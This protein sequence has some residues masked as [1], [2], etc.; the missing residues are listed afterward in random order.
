MS[1]IR[2]SLLVLTLLS[3]MHNASAVSLRP[4]DIAQL[5]TQAELVIHGRVISQEV[6]L[7]E[8]SQRVVT[9]T[10]FEVIDTL[11]GTTGETHRIKQLGGHLSGSDTVH[12]VPGV[13]RFVDGEE[14]IVFLPAVSRLGFS[15][16][17][18]LTQGNYRIT[19]KHGSATVNARGMTASSHTAAK[20][21]TG[22]ADKQIGPRVS[23]DNFKNLIRTLADER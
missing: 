3:C 7:D 12:R 21:V 11:K 19:R 10:T 6:T 18:G 15:S 16:P 23:V 22:N 8:T 1:L 2:Q 13:P 17:I 20:V 14:L 4:L 5:T 9:F